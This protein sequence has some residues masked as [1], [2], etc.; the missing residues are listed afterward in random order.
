MSSDHQRLPLIQRMSYSIGHVLNDLTA[1]IWFSYLIIYF[2]Q[3]KKFNNTLAGYLMLIGQI[4]DALFTPFIGYESDRTKG[5]RK[6]GKRKTWHFLGKYYNCN[7]HKLNYA[8]TKW[9]YMILSL[10]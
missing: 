5:I 8:T 3:V 1:S 6:L 4:S 10:S 9:K 2:H 7:K